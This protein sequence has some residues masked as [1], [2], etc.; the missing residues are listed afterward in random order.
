MDNSVSTTI[1]TSFEN[2][3]NYLEGCNMNDV[4][5]QINQLFMVEKNWKAWFEAINHMRVILKFIP[6]SLDYLVQNFGQ[7]I[8][9]CLDH[10][11]TNLTKNTLLLMQEIFKMGASHSIHPELI[12]KAI[13]I[14]LQ[15]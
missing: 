12:K 2:L 3:Q 9:A 5:N 14:L 8:L 6:Q 10:S 13:P 4:L 7:R 15:K 1:Y 11:T